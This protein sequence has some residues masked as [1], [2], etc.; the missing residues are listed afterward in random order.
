VQ[1]Q[2]QLGRGRAGQGHGAWFEIQARNYTRSGGRAPHRQMRLD[3]WHGA[4]VDYPSKNKGDDMKR[5]LYLAGLLAL[6]L[7]VQAASFDCAKA[8]TKVEKLICGDAELSKLDDE[9]AA[10]YKTALKD[11]AQA[12][13]IKQAQKRWLK[14]RDDCQD[15]QCLKIAYQS[16]RR[17]LASVSAQAEVAPNPAESKALNRIFAREADK[18]EGIKRIMTKEKFN[19]SDIASSAGPDFCGTFLADFRQMQGI[20]FVEPVAVSKTYDDP[21]WNSYK[22]GCPDLGLFESYSCEA[23]IAEGLDTLPQ[24]EREQAIK[25]YCRQS[26]CTENFKLFR[27]DAKV[28]GGGG[29]EGVFY[30]ERERG[31]FNWPEAKQLDTHGGYQVVD[32]KRCQAKDGVPSHDSYSYSFNHALENYNGIIIYKGKHYIFDLHEVAE[33]RTPEK[34]EYIL[35]VWGYYHPDRKEQPMFVPKCFFST[36]TPH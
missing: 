1:E 27:V 16:R 12:D 3:A 36:V 6:S 30:C 11:N 4:G 7:P 18:A 32:T 33:E 28:D 35:E 26:R 22:S 13:A 15:A 10:S 19:I 2:I 31:P 5:A 9:L 17:E 24:D 20:E 8:A 29:I 21:I 14:K 25:T 34:V 23:R